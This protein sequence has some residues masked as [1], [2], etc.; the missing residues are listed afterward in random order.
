M[1]KRD[2]NNIIVDETRT[3]PT[4]RKHPTNRNIGNQIDELWLSDLADMADYKT[5]NKNG[6]RYIFIVSD[7][8]SKYT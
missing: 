7:N 4:K 6:F 5:W 1:P 2:R 3:D 8:F